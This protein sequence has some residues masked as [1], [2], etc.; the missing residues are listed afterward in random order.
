LEEKN[1]GLVSE[2]KAL[3]SENKAL[4]SENKELDNECDD[5][6]K[7]WKKLLRR[8][9]EEIKKLKEEESEEDTDN[10]EPIEKCEEC[11]K[12]LEG[13]DKCGEACPSYDKGWNETH[14]EDPS[15]ED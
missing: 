5:H 15:A 14:E 8:K 1:K 10:E 12:C 4:V 7:R 9:N 3:V 11:G 2:N 13:E 6:V